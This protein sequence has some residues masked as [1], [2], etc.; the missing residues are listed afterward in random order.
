MHNYDR[1]DAG[2]L[3]TRPRLNYRIIVLE[4]FVVNFLQRRRGGG[5]IIVIIVI[6]P[7]FRIH[8]RR[9]CKPDVRQC[10]EKDGN[11]NE[12]VHG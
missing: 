3:N 2:H 12:S 5:T 11:D 4:R 7:I 1:S 10:K 9:C 6:V 8:G